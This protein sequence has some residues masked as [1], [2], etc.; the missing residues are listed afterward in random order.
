MQRIPDKLVS[1]EQRKNL[2]QESQKMVDRS[3]FQ[4][5]KVLDPVQFFIIRQNCNS[6]VFRTFRFL[7]ETIMTIVYAAVF[8][9]QPF[10]LCFVIFDFDAIRYDYYSP[11]LHVFFWIDILAT[12]I[13]GFYDSVS[14]EFILEQ[15]KIFKYLI[16]L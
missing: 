8:L 16:S 7:W 11:F 5:D 2:S 13:T 1:F 12:S 14:D 4:Q 6:R 15:S 10:V 3:P 9:I